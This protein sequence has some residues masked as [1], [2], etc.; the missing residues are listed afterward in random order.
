MLDL[1]MH[2][3][4]LLNSA[5]EYAERMRLRRNLLFYAM[6]AVLLVS[7]S[8]FVILRVAAPHM[9]DLAPVLTIS[10][11]ICLALPVII[12]MQPRAGLYILC[13]C[14]CLFLQNPSDAHHDPFEVIPFFWNIST[15][16]QF[17]GKT[18][19]L[20]AFHFNLGEGV[21]LTTFLFWM[22]RQILLRDVKL[23]KGTCF[24]SF[25]VFIGFCGFAFVRGVTSG[26]DITMALWEVRALFY[27][28]FAYLMATN[29][30]VTRE[31][32]L[33]LLF[34]IMLGIGAKSIFGT[35]NYIKNPNVSIEEGV[36]SHED[37]LLMNIIILGSLIF[38]LAKEEPIL[39]W[40]F[41]IFTPLAVAT[42]LAN[43]RR[44]GIACL[45]LAFP[46]VLMLCY[47]LLQKRRK[48]LG[49]FITVFTI[50]ASIYMPIA[51][52]GQGVWALPARAIRSH[53][54]PDERDA[55]SDSYRLAENQ[56]LKLTR[57]M[58]PWIGYGYG[59]PYIE[60]YYMPGRMDVFKLIL[61]HNGILWMWMR[62]GHFGFIAFWFFVL[63]MLVYGAQSLKKVTD[64]RLV[65]M[66]ILGLATLLM[67]LMY[68]EYDLNFANYRTM[69]I[70]G[71]LLGI[72]GVIP[73]LEKRQ[74][75]TKQTLNKEEETEEEFA[76]VR[77][78][79]NPD[80]LF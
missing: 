64:M 18:N 7:F 66:G 23:T 44:A 34:L 62:L 31:H 48:A 21:M 1:S 33:T 45:I 14:A 79:P 61:P 37:S 74:N 71:T 3:L 8:T 55:S 53:S 6:I 4:E 41:T 16:G 60:A 25:V 29:L 40:C 59:R 12:W 17:Y 77:S 5:Q 57:D 80:S 24:W 10:V 30:I 28:F 70:T 68:G 47:A 19:A 11:L 13:F 38:W 39:K 9:L 49:A 73:F 75:N 54:S 42:S 22:M 56:N 65:A 20:N 69:W 36:L 15:I 58:S 67:L 35:I 2:R 51:W 63:S 78:L 72:V 50:A 46:V 27:F 43:G 76:N 26:G 32:A 52:N